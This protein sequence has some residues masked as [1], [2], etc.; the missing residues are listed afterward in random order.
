M[1]KATAAPLAAGNPAGYMSNF[2]GTQHV[3]YRDVNGHIQELL[4]NGSW[5]INDIT[6]TTN[7]PLA[8]FGPNLNGY[9]YEVQGTEYV[10]YQDVND[11]IQQLCWNGNWSNTNLSQTTDAPMAGIPGGPSGYMFAAQ[12]T[13]HV[14][15]RDIDS[16]I[17]ELWWE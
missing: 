14:I 9:A 12:D 2:Q 15:Y 4:W 7:C 3:V 5:N 6:K 8:A 13:Q 16:H 1:T 17:Q 11:Q 10:F